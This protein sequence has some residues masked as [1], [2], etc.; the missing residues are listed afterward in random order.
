ML[1]RGRFTS[2]SQNCCW[3]AKKKSWNQNRKETRWNEGGEGKGEKNQKNGKKC[4]QPLL[5]TAVLKIVAKSG[6]FN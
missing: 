6:N 4:N 5:L 3:T 2:F 1:T